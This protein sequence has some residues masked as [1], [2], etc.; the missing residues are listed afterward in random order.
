MAHKNAVYRETLVDGRR[1]AHKFFSKK[2]SRAYD[3][4]RRETTSLLRLKKCPHV[5]PLVQMY[6]DDY[7]YHVMTEWCE[8]GAMSRHLILKNADAAACAMDLAK[9][10]QEI[11]DMGVIHGDIKHSNILCSSSLLLSDFEESRTVD[12]SRRDSVRG[13]ASYMSPEMFRAEVTKASDVW[14]VGVVVYSVLTGKMPFAARTMNDMF[15]SVRD[16]EPNFDSFPNKESRDFVR[17]CLAKDPK[18]R[19]SVQELVSSF[20]NAWIACAHRD[21]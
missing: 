5:V 15:L 6:E 3:A 1:V 2:C 14:A 10:V 17:S 13:T 7:G 19:P 16:T 9:A 11:H 8:R 20:G 18:E 12:D 4:Y 21:P